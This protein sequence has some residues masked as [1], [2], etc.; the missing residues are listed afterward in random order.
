MSCSITTAPKS[1]RHRAGLVQAPNNKD[2][3]GA[4]DSIEMQANVGA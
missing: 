3:P 4:G 2:H 1:I